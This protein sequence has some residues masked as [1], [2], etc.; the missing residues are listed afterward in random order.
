MGEDE[1]SP[2]Y[3]NKV[4]AN[5]L[6]NLNPPTPKPKVPTK[7]T[8]KVDKKGKRKFHFTFF[9]TQRELKPNISCNNSPA[10]PPT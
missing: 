7:K 4:I 10:Q 5:P 8:R 3:A 9:D 1:V 6:R 2:N